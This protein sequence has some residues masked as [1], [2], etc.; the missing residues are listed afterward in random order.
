MMRE[1]LKQF[2]SQQHKVA[3]EFGVSDCTLFL[4]DWVAWVDN[5]DP[6]ADFRGRYSSRAGAQCM[7]AAAGGLVSLVDRGGWWPRVGDPMPGDV[8]VV[9]HRP[10]RLV[11][12]AMAAPRGAICT[13]GYWAIKAEDWGVVYT[14]RQ[15]WRALKVWRHP[16]A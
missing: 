2:L 13:G 8:A 12:G 4:A 1:D 15:D 11:P 3:C 5:R 7:I 6:A 10:A 16:D 14:R 9:Q